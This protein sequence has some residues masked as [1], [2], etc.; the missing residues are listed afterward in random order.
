MR[1]FFLLL[2]IL[3]T[4]GSGYGQ[5]NFSGKWKLN[6]AKSQF[7]N[8]PITTAATKIFVD[9]KKT[10]ITLQRD[11]FPREN[12]RTDGSE[13]EIVSGNAVATKIKVSMKLTPDKTGLTEIRNFIYP[14][15][16][17]GTL[18]TRKTRKWS[19]SADK[20]TLTIQEHLETNHKSLSFHMVLVYEK[21]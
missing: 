8:T 4:T 20:K 13:T 5:L 9:Q 3:I 18:E 15:G 6:V 1:T 7:N 2:I 10:T 14:E 21:V 19:L 16:I 12:L 17:K 11:D